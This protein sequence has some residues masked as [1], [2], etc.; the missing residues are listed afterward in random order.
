M[1]SRVP[2]AQPHQEIPKVPPPPPA[3][4]RFPGWISCCIYKYQFQ[5]RGKKIFHGQL[6][7]QNGFPRAHAMY[8]CTVCFFAGPTIDA[9]LHHTSALAL[10]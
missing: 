9:L 10:D 5:V 4:A 6:A 1:G 8:Q 2:A 3:G 7:N